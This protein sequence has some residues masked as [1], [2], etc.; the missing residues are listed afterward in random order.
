[1]SGL[2]LAGV[3]EA[4]LPGLVDA[5][6]GDA[7]A[8]GPVAA[9]LVQCGGTLWREGAALV[10]GALAGHTVRSRPLTVVPVEGRRCPCSRW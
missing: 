10:C 9:E 6:V 1:M 2:V 7:A 5:Y 8:G 3:V 4:G